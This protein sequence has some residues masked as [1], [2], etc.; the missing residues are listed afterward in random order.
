MSNI[1]V[2]EKAISNVGYWTWWD[3]KLP[4]FFLLE[5]SGTLL[6]CSNA[7][8][9]NNPSST[10]SLIFENPITI[11]FLTKEQT[12]KNKDWH[13]LLHDDNIEPPTITDDK[14]TFTDDN[15]IQTIINETTS[16]E[17]ILGDGLKFIK[18]EEHKIQLAFWSG[19]VGLYIVAEKMKI[20][21]I[22]GIIELKNIPKLNDDWWEYWRDYWNKRET[23]HE[24]PQDYACEVIQPNN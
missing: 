17:N 15:L 7:S 23:S 12:E 18:R 11:N 22:N 1:A 24:Y 20:N 13:T 8:K 21:T 16:Y 6:L 2:L 14:F 10:I 3:K 9:E 5:L 19:D 4:N